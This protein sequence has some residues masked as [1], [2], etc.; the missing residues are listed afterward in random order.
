MEKAVSIFFPQLQAMQCSRYLPAHT[1]LPEAGD[2]EVEKANYR[3]KEEWEV[4]WDPAGAQESWREAVQIAPPYF[5]TSAHPL[6]I[7]HPFK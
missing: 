6:L 4:C 3:K 1:M 7:H 5:P 2:L